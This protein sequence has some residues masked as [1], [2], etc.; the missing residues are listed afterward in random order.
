MARRVALS[1]RPLVTAVWVASLSA[2]L[3][4]A[5]AAPSHA[6]DASPT[7]PGPAAPP[8]PAVP[9]VPY[10]NDSLGLSV[11]GPPGWKLTESKGGAPQWTSLA[12]FTDPATGAQAILATRRAFALT[13]P[14][15]RAEVTKDYAD[16]KTYSVGGIVDIPVSGKHPLPGL[17]VDATQAHL[18][19]PP[20]ATPPAPGTPPPAPPLPTVMRIQA[21]YLLGGDWEYLLVAQ[22]KGSLFSRL[23]PLLDRMFDSLV[24]RVQGSALAG[25]GGGQYADDVA[26]FQ[27][28]YPENYGV[29][30]PDRESQRVAFEPATAAPVLGVF[31]YPKAG[32]LEQEAK[33]LVD[34]YTGPEIGGEAAVTHRQVA[35]RDA[36]VVTAKGRMAGRDQVF[37]VA[38]V[39]RGDNTF[40]LRVA[41]DA[42]QEIAAKATFDAFLKSFVITN[43]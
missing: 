20:A 3:L 17:M 27:C 41:A 31:Y 18:D 28:R 34:Y 7:P 39:Q 11:E 1:P 25:R 35:G 24:V 29:R 32:D 6:Q 43:G 23:Q 21:M 22:T 8:A 5:L 33:V 16:D 4:A 38:I 42:T 40:R 36:S 2:L 9:G 12:T 15:L 14:R 19:T 30:L 10:K 26:G 37:Y 13:L